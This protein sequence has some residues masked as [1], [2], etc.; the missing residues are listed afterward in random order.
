MKQI[1]HLVRRCIRRDFHTVAHKKKLIPDAAQL[2]P[3]H[4]SELNNPVFKCQTFIIRLQLV[5]DG[6]PETNTSVP[7]RS[8]PYRI[9][10]S[11]GM[12]PALP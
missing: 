11:I 1:I 8:D 10:S 7:S 9:P 4:Y 5:C 12:C 6:S 3:F 2:V